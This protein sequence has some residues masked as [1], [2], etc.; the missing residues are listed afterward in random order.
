VGLVS[1]AATNG[2]RVVVGEAHDAARA[3]RGVRVERRLHLRGYTFAPPSVRA[4]AQPGSHGPA[5]RGAGLPSGNA[6][7][8]RCAL[9]DEQLLR[10]RWGEL[11]A[12]VSRVGGMRLGVGAHRLPTCHSIGGSIARWR[13]SS[14]GVGRTRAIGRPA[15]ATGGRALPLRGSGRILLTCLPTRLRSPAPR[16]TA[17]TWRPLRLRSLGSRI[18]TSGDPLRGRFRRCP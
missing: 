3:H 17:C 6:A 1:P 7:T 15:D 13:R 8:N 11:V 10:V 2:E 5:L 18:R 4:D 12:R 14:A 9:R 16:A